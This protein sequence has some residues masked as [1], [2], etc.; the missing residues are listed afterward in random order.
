VKLDWALLA[1][2]AFAG[3]GL[4][5]SILAAGLT[6]IGVPSRDRI[7]PNFAVPDDAASGPI[8]LAVVM[9][10][11]ASRAEVGRQSKIEITICGLDGNERFKLEAPVPIPMAPP[12][13]PAGSEIPMHAVI[14]I[15]WYPAKIETHSVNVF[16]DGV[17][18]KTIPLNIRIVA[19]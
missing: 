13:L 15:N 12:D 3:P 14:E 4:P 9:G 10:L 7:P 16:I 6:A 11:L 19:M 1:K 17:L 2:A 5:P 18:A 8:Q